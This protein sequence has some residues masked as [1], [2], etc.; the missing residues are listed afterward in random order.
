MKTGVRQVATVP[1]SMAPDEDTLEPAPS[2]VGVPGAGNTPSANPSGYLEDLPKYRSGTSMRGDQAEIDFQAQRAIDNR[3][4]LG[5]QD[6]AEEAKLRGDPVEEEIAARA[7]TRK[8][9]DLMPAGSRPSIRAT[10]RPGMAMSEVDYGAPPP[11][12]PSVGELR[13]ARAAS[14][15]LASNPTVATET[16]KEGNT[17]QRQARAQNFVTQ[18][19]QAVA[20]MRAEG[21]PDLE[22]RLLDA[23]NSLQARLTGLGFP[24]PTPVDPMRTQ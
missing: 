20:R 11:E 12:A 21:G 3:Y 2:V 17:A 9:E 24:P 6:S 15:S 22:Q 5:L 1:D 23:R 10:L 7:K 16:M 19:N 8:L 18:Y 13:A 14:L 4:K